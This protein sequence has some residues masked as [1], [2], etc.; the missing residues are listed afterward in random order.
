MPVENYFVLNQKK[1]FRTHL[2]PNDSNAINKFSNYRSSTE[3]KHDLY[4]NIL[5]ASPGFRNPNS[6]DY[7]Y[8]KV[9][10]SST[11]IYTNMSGLNGK[12]PAEEYGSEIR[13]VQASKWAFR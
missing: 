5:V 12:F 4:E 3:L 6:I 8:E 1:Q 10:L 11:S 13:Q 2:F 9:G 7:L